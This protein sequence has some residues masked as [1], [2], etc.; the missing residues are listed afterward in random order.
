MLGV[1]CDNVSANERMVENLA[2]IVFDFPGDANRA[3]CL[4]HI[5][6]LVVKI[7]L[8]QFDMSKKKGKKDVPKDNPKKEGSSE[9]N[10]NEMTEQDVD[11]LVRGLD[12]EE[13]EMYEGDNE[14]DNEE[15]DKVL[16]DVKELE[17]VLEEELKEVVN[18]AKP[19]CQVLYKVSLSLFFFYYS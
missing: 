5:V 13:K 15:S 7:M 18:L 19:V 11:E 6:N 9:D 8:C 14:D 2:K 17:V 12:K 3:R 1:T 4:A 16:R 10:E